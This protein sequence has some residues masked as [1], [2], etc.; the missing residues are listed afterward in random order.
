M[1]RDFFCKSLVLYTAHCLLWCLI[2]FF[3]PLLLVFM[4]AAV[5]DDIVSVYKVSEKYLK[6]FL[7]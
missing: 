3:V 4:V 1:F 7:L 6:I 2:S 5:I